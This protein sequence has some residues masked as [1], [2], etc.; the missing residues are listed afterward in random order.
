M[1]FCIFKRLTPVLILAVLVVACSPPDEPLP[2]LMQFP[3]QSDLSVLP[4]ANNERSSETVQW[5]ITEDSVNAYACTS[6]ECDV[7]RALQQGDQIDVSSTE[8]EWHRVL[9]GS[10]EYYV[11]V[12][13]T[14]QKVDVTPTQ[15]PTS[16]ST[17]TPTPTTT[18]SLTYTVTPS[19]TIT[20]TSTA[21]GTS[22]QTVE[23]IQPTTIDVFGTPT[24]PPSSGIVVL[25]TQT[26]PVQV[27]NNDTTSTDDTDNTNRSEPTIVATSKPTAVVVSTRIPIATQD[28]SDPPPPVLPTLIGED[29]EPPPPVLPG[30]TQPSDPSVLPDD[31]D[32]PPPVLPTLIGEDDE[33]PPPSLPTS[34]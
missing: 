22:P 27:P 25:S 32:P 30:S 13:Y 4:I 10:D 11:E 29:D 17:S 12:K 18:P 21:T 6:V 20:S 26:G 16:T 33:P 3:T 28:D 24:I 8:A 5:E 9:D 15:T 34:G 1:Y 31:S 14:K 7:V 19:A 23:S 2:T